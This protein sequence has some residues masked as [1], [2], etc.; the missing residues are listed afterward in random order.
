MNRDDPE[1]WGRW[2]A[3]EVRAMV[4]RERRGKWIE[5]TVVLILMAGLV[6]MLVWSLR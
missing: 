6:A 1:R 4:E 5:V 3:A 2:S